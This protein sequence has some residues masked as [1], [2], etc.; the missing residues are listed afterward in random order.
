MDS[1]V[2]PRNV[3]VSAG[4][5]EAILPH[6]V[7]LRY[8]PCTKE[9]KIERQKEGGSHDYLEPLRSRKP[10]SRYIYVKEL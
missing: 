2:S 5:P 4:I 10:I 6:V 3:N 7:T 9:S 1:F 8:K